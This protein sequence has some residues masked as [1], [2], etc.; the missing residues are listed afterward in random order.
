MIQR[1][2][3]NPCKPS[4]YKGFSYVYVLRKVA[5]KWSIFDGSTHIAHT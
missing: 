3:Q 2:Y 4:V 1:D 5:E